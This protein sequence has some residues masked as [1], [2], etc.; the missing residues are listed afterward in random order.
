MRKNNL[1]ANKIAKKLETILKYA[2]R[3]LYFVIYNL[4]IRCP[5]NNEYYLGK[6]LK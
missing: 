6:V 2:F 3:T 4:V 1:K 5:K